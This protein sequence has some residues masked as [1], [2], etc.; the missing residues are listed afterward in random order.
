MAK[1]LVLSDGKKVK[2]KQGKGIDLLHA[3][4]KAKTSEEMLQNAISTIGEKN[5]VVILMHD[6]GDKIL[7]YEMLPNLISYLREK[8]YEFKNMY[9]LIE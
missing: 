9:D 2:I 1:E 3:Q 5:S 6:A 8:G 4:M 7:T